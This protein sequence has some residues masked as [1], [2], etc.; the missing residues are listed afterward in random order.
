MYSLLLVEI[1]SKQMLRILKDV[2]E[3][4]A[5]IYLWKSMDFPIHFV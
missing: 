3:K 5:L 4:V 2:A 1:Y